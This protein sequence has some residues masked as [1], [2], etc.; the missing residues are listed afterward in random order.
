M[1]ISRRFKS[2]TEMVEFLRGVVI[3]EGTGGTG[4]TGSSTFTDAAT[5]AFDGVE[6]GDTVYV[7]GIGTFE[8]SSVTDVNTL[9]LDAPLSDDAA[10]VHWRVTRGAIAKDEILNA[11]F[12]QLSHQWVVVYDALTFKVV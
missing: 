9:E 6:A 7:S 2:N 1:L 5:D 12:E 3:V 4:S 10:G 8:V 11:S